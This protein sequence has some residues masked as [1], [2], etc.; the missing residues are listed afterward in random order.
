ME[1]QP[2][3]TTA[4]PATTGQATAPGQITR[5]AFLKLLIVQLQ[6]Q[7]PLN[8][9]DN[10][11]FVS[12]LTAFNSLDQLIGLNEKMEGFQSQQLLL[13]QMGAVSLIGKQV[14]AGGNEVQLQNGAEATLHYQLAADADQVTVQIQD[15]SGRLVRT[16]QAGGQKLGERS[17][18]WD[19]KDGLGQSLPSGLY[20]FEVNAVDG[21]GRRVE[22]IGRT[23]GVVTGVNLA[24]GEAVLEIGGVQVP[25]SAVISVQ[26]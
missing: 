12:Q 1:V 3:N 9:L 7:D 19:G 25:M 26:Q 2:I 14:V 8:P 24:G 21:N 10:Q 5:D 17:V 16:L 6:H 4:T 20:T 22:A 18:L 15:A 23:R 11:E 13:S